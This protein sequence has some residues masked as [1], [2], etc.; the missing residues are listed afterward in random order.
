[1]E[2]LKTVSMVKARKLL[3]GIVANRFRWN[4]SEAARHFGCSPTMVN[5]VLIGTHP[6]TKA[7]EEE[8]GIV[9]KKVVKTI[10]YYVE[11]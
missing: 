8:L 10:T 3:E 4:K 1:M 2:N 5:N 7:M 9:D 11:K 6:L